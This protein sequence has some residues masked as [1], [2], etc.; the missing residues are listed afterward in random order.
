MDLVEG[1]GGGACLRACCVVAT[2]PVPR[3]VKYFA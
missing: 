1:G 2:C 3:G